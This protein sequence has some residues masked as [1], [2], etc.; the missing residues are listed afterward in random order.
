[1]DAPSNG[2]AEASSGKRGTDDLMWK[3][4]EAGDDLVRGMPSQIDHNVPGTDKS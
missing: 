1:M 3:A 4:M 2:A